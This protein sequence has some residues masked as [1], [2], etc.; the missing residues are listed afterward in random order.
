MDFTTTILNSSPISL[1][2]EDICFISLSMLVSVPVFSKVVMARV[3]IDLLAS[4]TN[5]S[6]SSLHFATLTGCNTATSLRVACC[7]AE[8]RLGRG[9]EQLQDCHSWVEVTSLYSRQVAHCLSSLIDHHFILVPQTILQ[10]LV[11][12]LGIGGAHVFVE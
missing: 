7:K 10:E 5:S 1:M 9:E 8:R 6:M 11:R 4:D 3:A 12:S 2:N